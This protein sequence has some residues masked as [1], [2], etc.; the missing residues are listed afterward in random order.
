MYKIIIT[1]ILAMCLLGC[2]A[3]QEKQTVQLLPGEIQTPFNFDLQGHRGARGLYPENS[4]VAFE[5]AIELGI[6]TLELDVVVTKD[7]QILVS[8]DPFFNHIICLDSLGNTINKEA[9]LN[10]NIYQ[11]TY[12]QVQQFDCGSIKHPQFPEQT[13]S[14]ISKPLLL[15]VIVQSELLSDQ[16]INYNIEIKST[17]EGDNKYHPTPQVF[18][19]LFIKTIL[20]RVPMERLTIQSF[21]FRVLRY[22]HQAYPDYKLTALVYK[23]SVKTNLDALGFIP[24][25]YSPEHTLLTAEIVTELQAKGMK[26]IPWTI[27]EASRMKTVLGWGVDGIITDYP[28]RGLFFKK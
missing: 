9:E 18:A 13:N 20:G 26:V 22:I 3:K 24:D 21:D 16:K 2:K 19:D 27:N 23:D 28:D 1:A 12:S 6:N 8:H 14:T 10:L 17:P 11:T 7:H 15:D 5:K 4:L 25:S